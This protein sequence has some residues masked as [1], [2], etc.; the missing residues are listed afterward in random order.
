ML[1]QHFIVFI[2]NFCLLKFVMC[3]V[4]VIIIKHPSL[5]S[6]FGEEDNKKEPKGS[7]HFKVHRNIL[8]EN[9]FNHFVQSG[10]QL[11]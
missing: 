7:N 9:K 3:V 10:A 5:C 6:K 8:F 1:F 11:Y 4:D 2:W